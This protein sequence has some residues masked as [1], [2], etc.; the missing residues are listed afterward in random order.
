MSPRERTAKAAPPSAS[1][2]D[3]FGAGSA[4]KPPA[5]EPPAPAPPPTPPPKPKPPTRV[6]LSVGE[7][8]SQLK[9]AV[10][11]L[12]P[13][14]WVRGEI[15]GYRGPNTRGHLYFTLKDQ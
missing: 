8:T 6:V 3:L 5:R 13:H 7:L 2:G 10:E 14:V 4:P 9:G 15:S 12:F 11:G 1:Q